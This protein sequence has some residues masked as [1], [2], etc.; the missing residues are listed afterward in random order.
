MDTL[1]VRVPLQSLPAAQ[2]PT[3]VNFVPTASRTRSPRSPRHLVAVLAYDGLCTFEF[4]IAVELFGLPRPE[5]DNWYDF[6]VCSDT[7]QPLAATGGIHVVANTNL[8]VLRR[9][10]TIIIPGWRSPNERPSQRLIDELRRAHGRGARLVSICSGVFVLAATGLLDGRRAT[11][12]WRYT[13]ELSRQ[14]PRISVDPDVLYLDEGRI[15]TS[16]GSAAGID[17]CLHIV[18]QDYGARIA[19]EVARR[20]VMSPHR[21]GGQAQFIPRPV[22]D[23]SKPWLSRLLEW[24]ERRLHEPLTVTRLARAANMSKRT[25]SRH[26]AEA[27]GSSPAQWVIRLRV[28]RA[29]ELLET[30]SLSV[31]RIASDCGFGSSASLRHHFRERVRMSPAA[32]RRGQRT[33]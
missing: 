20:L 33:R 1:H 4:G 31:E 6:V 24:A 27:T 3:T 7:P 16:A 26:F 12:H 19:N 10:R 17:L 22:A 28:A 9:A 11:T 23:T 30:T 25:L 13:D 21:D 5:L 32:Y 29:R 15:L 18:R 8:A 14:Y 2:R